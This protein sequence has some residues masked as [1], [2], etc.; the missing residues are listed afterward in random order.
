ML[1]P[2]DLENL[3]YSYEGLSNYEKHTLIEIIQL[4]HRENDEFKN[5]QRSPEGEPIITGD[6]IIDDQEEIIS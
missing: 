2:S 5:I 4:L 3:D 1:E 6:E